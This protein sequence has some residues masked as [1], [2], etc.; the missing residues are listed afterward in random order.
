[1]LSTL[2]S[3]VKNV[4]TFYL[5]SDKIEQAP[6]VWWCY[7]VEA[8]TVSAGL[9]KDCFP[10]SG[11]RQTKIVYAG[12][13]GGEM[14]MTEEMNMGAVPGGEIT[15]QDKLWAALSYIFAPLIGIIVLLMEENK[16]RPYQKYHAVQSIALAIVLWIL[17][18]ILGIVLGAVTSFLGCLGGFC[19][20][21][22]WLLPFYY[23]YQS[24]QGEWIEIPV[25]TDFLK[26]QNWI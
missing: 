26:G 7:L 14:E 12:R 19:P 16:K 3:R 24:Y 21:L 22:L 9:L 20:M 6:V 25:L 11:A 10:V 5:E 1:M 23:A 13:E 4:L 17:I 15:D 2:H 8:E 18:V